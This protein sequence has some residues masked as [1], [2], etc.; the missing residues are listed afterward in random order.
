MGKITPYLRSQVIKKYIHS[1]SMNE[2]VRETPLSKGTVNNI[3]QDWRLKIKG[4][5]IEEIRA[6][7][8]EVRKSGITIEE[9]AQG[10]RIVQLLKKFDI[11][12][13][14]DVSVNRTD[15]FEDLDLDANNS[16]FI[17]DKN[18]S[19]QYGNAATNFN[20][21]VNIS[22]KTEIYNIPYFLNH[23]YK[24]CKKHDITPN[25]VI[26]WIDDLLS[27]FHDLDTESDEDNDYI[28]TISS[29]LNNSV[30][31]KQNEQNIRKEI[32]FVSRLSFYIKRKEKRI[33]H[34]ENIINSFS[35]KI[36]DLTKQRQDLVSRINK[37]IKI[38]K[39]VF[40][41]FKWYENLKQE[42]LYKYSLLIEQEFGTFAN[43][44][45]DFKQYDFDVIKI[46]TE[47]RN[48]S[49]LRNDVEITQNQVDTNKATRDALVLEV[50]SLEESKN[51]N[52][53]AINTFNEL[54][55]IGIGLKEL[56]EL[57]NI[58]MES[59]FAN[60]FSV[61]DAVKKFFIDLEK[62]Y[63][64]K[65]GFEKKVEE[66]KSQMKEIEYQIPG[67][68]QYLDLYIGAVSTLSHLNA[69]GVTN[70]SIINMNQLFSIFRNSDFLS[71]PLDQNADKGFENRD[72]PTKNNETIYWQQFI[73]KLQSIRN[74]NQEINKQ[75]SNLN[76]LHKQI[77]VLNNNKQLLE[78]TY[79]DVVSNLQ[80]ILSTI[81]QSIDMA[82]QINESVEKKK[83]VPVPI[84]FTVFVNSG[85]S[86]NEPDDRK[87]KNKTDK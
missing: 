45:E 34:L 3:L 38:E 66:L 24:N 68:K 19:A 74:I 59:A 25:I 40:S 41:Y 84:V 82:R 77:D 12:D 64:N 85:T 53:Q 11:T 7:T 57:S 54:E 76:I 22:T 65:L 52:K 16:D 36:D 48:I 47:Y 79:N 78:V 37:I 69:N 50:A 8:S 43:A 2:I 70:T 73:A 58:I 61:K 27:S 35:K 42:L 26:G 10:F 80:N 87:E 28:D 63:D 72:D 5:D 6:F 71:N 56:K 30:E 49:S 31:K 13:E 29:D 83:I 46:L 67:Y 55:K 44:V 18:P 81:H 62:Q 21:N 39:R 60:K 33:R 75:I 14:F 9:C 23:I 86:N 51:Y 15:E 1:L 17:I 20:N 4:T 32:P